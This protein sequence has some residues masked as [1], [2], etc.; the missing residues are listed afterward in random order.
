MAYYSFTKQILAG[1]PIRIFNYGKMRRDFT[2]IDDIVDGVLAALER[3]PAANGNE[4]PACIYNLGNSRSEN[5]MDFV[6]A[7]E[8]ALGAKATYD[9]QPMQPGD[10]Q[11]TSAD[12]TA[13]TKDL[14]FVPHTRMDEGIAK[15]VAW[16]KGYYESKK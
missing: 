1:E 11:E 12:I 10:V 8:K 16:Y 5:L 14:G 3:P 6:A 4:P 7:L 13:S 15:F 9:F 2:Y